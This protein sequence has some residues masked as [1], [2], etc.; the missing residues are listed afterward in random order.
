MMKT[1]RI[2]K[3]QMKQLN[4]NNKFQKMIQDSSTPI[5][6]LNFRKEFS[7]KI[8][9]KVIN[10]KSLKNLKITKDKFKNTA[11]LISNLKNLSKKR[12]LNQVIFKN[13]TN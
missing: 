10:N 5:K 7:F 8:I 12:T 1:L 11:N 9:Y 13:D 2:I 6:S 3:N 4:S